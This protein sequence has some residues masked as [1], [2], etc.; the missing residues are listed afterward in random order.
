MIKSLTRV[1][2]HKKYTENCSMFDLYKK[3]A[4]TYW[5]GVMWFE[6][7]MFLIFFLLYLYFVA[8]LFWGILVL[9]YMKIS[10]GHKNLNF[11]KALQPDNWTSLQQLKILFCL[12][13]IT[14]NLET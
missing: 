2:T 8:L 5:I 3:K 4:V 11:N 1:F 9:S 13:K 7:T 12:N 6:V 14:Y 10:I